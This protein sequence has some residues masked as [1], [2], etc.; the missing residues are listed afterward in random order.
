[1][2]NDFQEDFE[3]AIKEEKVINDC[4]KNMSENV[5]KYSLADIERV[6]ES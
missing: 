3:A 4:L 1:M 5:S 6:V 2:F